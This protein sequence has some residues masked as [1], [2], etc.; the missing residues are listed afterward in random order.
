LR[1]YSADI[2][3]VGDSGIPGGEGS[4]GSGGRVKGRRKMKK[5]CGQHGDVCFESV[6]KVPEGANRVTI[7]RGER[8]F[9][10]ERGEGVH[11]HVLTSDLNDLCDIVEIYEHE[12][13]MYVKVKPGK[14]VKITHEEHGK[15]TLMPGIVRKSIEREYSYAENE[16]K[17]VID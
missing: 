9:I 6:D 3:S 4:V 14:Q 8:T 13:S 11:T 2:I 17:R 16:E 10:V 1:D 5:L 15:K 12:G 7:P